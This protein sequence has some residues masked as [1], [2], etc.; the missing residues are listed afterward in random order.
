MCSFGTFS[1]LT[2]H[3]PSYIFV[4]SLLHPLHFS[5]SLSL[6]TVKKRYI[7]KRKKKKKKLEIERSMELMIRR[8][9]LIMMMFV[10]STIV[11]GGGAKLSPN[12]YRST[13]PHV[14]EIVRGAVTK[15]ISQTVVTIPA[16]LRLFFHDCFVEVTI[17]SFRICEAAVLVHL[18]ISS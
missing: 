3:I 18:P 14:E 16:T 11:R 2:Q 6:F 13:C 8:S 9:L 1:S 5:L 12:F 10:L 17:R 7:K 4:L 15:K